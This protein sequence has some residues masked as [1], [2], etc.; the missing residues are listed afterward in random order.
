MTGNRLRC[1]L[2]VFM[3]GVKTPAFPAHQSQADAELIG[4]IEVRLGERPD[5]PLTR[6]PG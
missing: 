5:D 6:H 2:V 3:T 4:A 1:A